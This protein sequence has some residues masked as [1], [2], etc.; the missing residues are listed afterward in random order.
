MTRDCL[1]T[2]CLSTN[3]VAERYGFHQDTVRA[4]RKANK[5]PKYSK[6]DHGDCRYRYELKD[7]L[8]WEKEHNMTPVEGG[9]IVQFS[10]LVQGRDE[11]HERHPRWK[12]LA[13]FPS[14]GYAS[15]CIEALEAHYGTLKWRIVSI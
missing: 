2:A 6:R 1:V 13:A 14:K 9:G 5:G 4:W 8:A 11:R 10:W 15:M 7:L 12:T 3:Q